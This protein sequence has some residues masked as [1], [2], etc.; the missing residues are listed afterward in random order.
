MTLDPEEGEVP[1]GEAGEGEVPGGLSFFF[2]TL[3]RAPN[4][5]KNFFSWLCSPKM[6]EKITTPDAII[7]SEQT[8]TKE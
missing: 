3:L 1:G 4:Y 5:S 7:S 6:K 2:S 8:H